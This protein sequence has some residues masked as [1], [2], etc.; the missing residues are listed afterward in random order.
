MTPRKVPIIYAARP[1]LSSPKHAYIKI[2]D[3]SFGKGDFS[4]NQTIVDC[5]LKWKYEFL[6]ILA[7][8]SGEK[9]QVYPVAYENDLILMK[10]I[11]TYTIIHHVCVW[12]KAN[13]NMYG[14]S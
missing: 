5:L 11:H 12:A 9:E 8:E 6:V 7:V 1:I 10:C 3:W 4:T 14:N 2:D 13:S